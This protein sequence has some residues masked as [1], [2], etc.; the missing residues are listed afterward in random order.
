MIQPIRI[1]PLRPIWLREPF[2]KGF[3]NG[4]TNIP[5]AAGK[6]GVYVIFEGDEDAGPESFYPVYVGASG[7]KA[8]S[9]GNLKKAIMRHFYAYADD[10]NDTSAAYNTPRLF[11]KLQDRVSY[12]KDI[13]KFDYYA[14]FYIFPTTDGKSAKR[15]QEIKNS[16]ADLEREKIKELKPRDNPPPADETPSLEELAPF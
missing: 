7:A 12:Y 10:A 9:R 16:I 15:T 14:R 11:D 6:I 8:N 1:I 13:G 3:T 4:R 2:A 5:A